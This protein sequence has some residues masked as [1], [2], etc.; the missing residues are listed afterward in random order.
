MAIIKKF[1]ASG[2]VAAN[3]FVALNVSDQT[4]NQTSTT[5]IDTLGVQLNTTTTAG[6]AAYVCV[7]G[8]CLVKVGATAAAL[9]P[10]DQIS[11][12]V[13]VG[14]EGMAAIGNVSLDAALGVYYGELSNGAYPTVTAGDLVT[15]YVYQNKT[16]LIA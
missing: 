4:V 11:V 14:S 3:T 2:A 5:A 10:N 7:E 16:R 13:A 15:I 6:D 8:E 9:T 1:Q 12:D